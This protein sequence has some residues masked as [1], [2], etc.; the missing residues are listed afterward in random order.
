MREKETATGNCASSDASLSLEKHDDLR[1]KVVATLKSPQCLINQIPLTQLRKEIVARGRFECKSIIKGS[2][3]RLL[4]VVGPC[5]IHNAEEA[6]FYA[7]KLKSYADESKGDL[8]VVMR[9][10]FEKPRS[11]SG[12]KGLISDPDLDGSCNIGRG[13]EMS[14]RIL[15]EVVDVGLPT[16]CEFLNPIIHEYLCDFVSRGAIGARTAESQPHREM[17]SGLPIPVG[18]KNSTTG[19]FK[20]AV[21]TVSVARSPLFYVSISKDGRASILS[22]QGN[23]YCHVVLRG[24]SSGTNYDK[25]SIVSVV[26]LAKAAGVNPRVMIDCSHGNSNKE[27]TRQKM[28]VDDICHQ[29]TSCDTSS[30]ILGVMIESNINEGRQDFDTILGEDHCKLKYGVSITDACISW[31]ETVELL[32]RL[33]E[34][35]RIRRMKSSLPR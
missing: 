21:S 3:D 2:D 18:C 12:W 5:S 20:S 19:E 34:A 14:R 6:I 28:V 27:L 7:R 4:V 16:A 32:D 29:L 9:T 23:D 26:E 13:I 17:I 25:D 24:G 15:C 33:R 11:A 30:Y 10:Y 8:C 31:E 22:T 1:A 35:V